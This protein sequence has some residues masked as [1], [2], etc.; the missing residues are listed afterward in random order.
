MASKNLDKSNAVQQSNEKQDRKV[1]GIENDRIIVV[2][3]NCTP[4]LFIII[5]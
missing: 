5:I 4:L 1:R 3:K 2:G